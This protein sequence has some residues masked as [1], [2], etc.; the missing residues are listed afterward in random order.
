MQIS[1]L[2]LIKLQFLVFFSVEP[3]IT[4]GPSRETISEIGK[5]VHLPCTS[6]GNPAPE[7]LWYKNAQEI[8]DS[9]EERFEILVNG[10]LQ[11]S[12]LSGV[13]TG[14]YQCVVRN[15]GGEK[16]ASTWLHVKSKFLQNLQ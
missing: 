11:I 8:K 12:A 7:V 1:K 3:E 9:E 2:N 5:T 6:S 10:T 14:I 4:H 13:D 16:S 15:I